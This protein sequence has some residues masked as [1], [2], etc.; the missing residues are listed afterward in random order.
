MKTVKNLSL[1][2]SC[3]LLILGCKTVN[4]TEVQ[5]IYPNQVID[6]TLTADSNYIKEIA[7]YKNRLD[8]IMN[9][10]IT[11]AKEDFTKE[12]YSSNEGNLLAD[13]LLDFSKKYAIP[14]PDFCLLNIGGVRTIIP[15]GTVTVGN[16]FEVAPFENEIAFV[17]LDASQMKEMF[18]YLGKEK[19][20]HPLAGIKIAYKKGKLHSVEIG[21]KPFDPN[22]KYWVVTIDYL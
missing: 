17:R 21:G 1:I 19:K 11:Y 3:I 9:Q 15:K 16:I 4:L 10:P 5:H 2:S 6:S 22:K 18:D 20:G 7:P 12:G 13:L 14:A 8:S